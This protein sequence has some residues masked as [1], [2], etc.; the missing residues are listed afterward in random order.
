MSKS[1]AGIAPFGKRTDTSR[2]ASLCSRLFAM[3]DGFSECISLATTFADQCQREC[4]SQF[5]GDRMR[6]LDG[7]PDVDE[8]VG[9]LIELAGEREHD[10]SGVDLTPALAR[11]IVLQSAPQ[12]L[13]AG[14]VLQNF[15]NAA[16]CHEPVR[17]LAHGIHGWHVGNGVFENN[18]ATLFRQMLESLDIALPAINS[19]RFD[20]SADFLST[21]W[22]LTAYRLSLSLFPRRQCPEI[23]GA[24]LY[25]LAVPIPR[26]VHDLKPFLA[27]LGASVK[28]FAACSENEI[29]LLLEKAK[30]AI[31]LTVT[32]AEIGPDGHAASEDAASMMERIAVGFLTSKAL[33]DEWT[34]SVLD[35]IAGAELSP[36]QQMVRL[37]RRKAKF[38][39]GYH[40]RLK[41]GGRPFDEL[42]VEDPAAF[43]HALARTAW[44][45]PGRPDKSRLLTQL[46][47]FGGPMF[48]IFSHAEISAI[49][50]WIASL[51][52]TRR[53]PALSSDTAVRNGASD[54]V[55]ARSACAPSSGAAIPAAAE[56]HYD[57]VPVREL[58]FQLLN[59]E[60]FPEARR[61][62]LDFARIWLARSAA[63]MHRGDRAL[64]FP[65]YSHERLRDWFETLGLEQARSYRSMPNGTDKSREEVIAEA[66]H[67][68][69][70]ILIDGGWLQRWGNTGLVD[71]R[72]GAL[73]YKILS[74]EIGN[75]DV[76]LNHPKLYRGLMIQMGV[77]LPEHSTLE[78]ARS[79][80]FSD[81]AF[82]VPTFWLSISHFP[83]RFLPETL[84]LNLAME[85]S[86]VGGAYR[87]ARDELR[88]YGFSTLFV[89]LHNTIDNI[90]TGHSAM[91]AEAIEI[92]LD[93]LVRAGD[94]KIIDAH[95]ERVWTGYRALA[96][97]APSWKELLVRPQYPY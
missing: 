80:T 46:I 87:T 14:C 91:A 58:Y 50:D 23:L 65:E 75:G 59:I 31:R 71:T 64:P 36:F 19:V 30:S 68:C 43:V 77:E 52:D 2:P 33:M 42:I 24:M 67:L 60:R 92:Y 5:N 35:R 94:R 32:E 82:L 54:H 51:E 37:V 44:V 78:F 41:I 45:A 62:G 61:R 83:R 89:D 66:V 18:R 81:D 85:L 21:A 26:I 20:R 12:G 63:G 47:Q 1:D 10:L 74:D 34:D 29:P 38:A 70:M 90:S 88:H 93:D 13:S 84:G 79:K 25:E 69:P 7:S 53:S 8:F 22:K 73:L 39:V 9:R 4:A 96:P 49:R 40:G 3:E 6:V 16:N 28:I 56:R 55:A 15:S 97:P 48:R 76:A 72:V 95:W 86:G 27:R 57:A 11:Y 17:T